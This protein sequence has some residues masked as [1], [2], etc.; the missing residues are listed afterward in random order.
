V[1]R[2]RGVQTET[3]VPVRVVV[4]GEELLAERAGISQAAEPVG[5]TGAN[6]SV[7]NADSENGLSLEPP[8]RR[9]PN[10]STSP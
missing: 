10:E 3:G 7:L 1:H 2:G 8:L 9:S 4:V 6:W 5:K